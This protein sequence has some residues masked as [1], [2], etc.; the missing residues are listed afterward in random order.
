MCETSNELVIQWEEKDEKRELCWFSFLEQT[1][2]VLNSSVLVGACLWRH[3]G[4]FDLCPV[5]AATKLPIYKEFC[6]CS[7]SSDSR[8]NG[9]I[10]SAN[11]EIIY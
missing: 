5:K 8:P 11:S 9:E 1:S 7:F 6:I 3:S 10:F 4:N 2:G